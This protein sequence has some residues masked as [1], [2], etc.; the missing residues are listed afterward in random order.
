MLDRN[1]S[2]NEAYSHQRFLIGEST[3]TATLFGKPYNRSLSQL[4]DPKANVRQAYGQWLGQVL[5][6]LQVGRALAPNPTR[7]TDQIIGPG[8]LTV[9]VPAGARVLYRNPDLPAD[10]VP[11]ASGEAFVI[12]PSSCPITLMERAGTALGLHTGRD[13]LIDRELVMYG[14]PATGRKYHSICF[15]ALQY[16]Q[17]P[18][19][20]QV[21]V[22]WSVPGHRFPHPL[23]GPTHG[24]FNQKLHKLLVGRWGADCAPMRG[25]VFYLDLPKLIKAQCLEF[26]VPE[27]HIDLTHAYQGP[28]GTWQEGKAGTPRNLLVL[29]RRS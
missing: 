18:R 29:A 1:S 20:V 26:G 9:P 16:L 14:R 13:C 22:L 15:A 2:L 5:Y 24:D 23:E 17:E 7:F 27:D 3:F 6:D 21:K 4:N 11:I 10:G 19:E 28:E 8:Q 12:S 25:G